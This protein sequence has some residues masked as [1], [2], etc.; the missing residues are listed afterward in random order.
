MGLDKEDGL[1]AGEVGLSAFSPELVGALYRFRRV[2]FK[3]R[4]LGMN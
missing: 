3:T 4:F 2:Q 1:H